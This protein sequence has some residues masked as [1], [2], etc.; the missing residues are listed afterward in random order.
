MSFVDAIK[1]C[2]GKYATFSG[3]AARSEFWYFAL[4][5][6]I[7]ATVLSVADTALFGA[8]EVAMMAADGFD[9]GMNFSMAWQ[10]QPLSGIFMLIMLLPSI[11]V[12][13]RRL[14]DTNRSGWWYWIALI[15][16]I[17]FIV[18]LVF[19]VGKGTDGDNDYGPDPLA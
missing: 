1:T 7:V 18:L 2:F 14:H 13:V 8:R 17:G 4:F 3:R 5:Y 10:P 11:S 16:F 6:F 9:T 15:P 19:F 12:A